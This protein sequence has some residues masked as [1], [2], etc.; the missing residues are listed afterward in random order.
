MTLGPEPAAASSVAVL[1]ADVDRR[2]RS[3][4]PAVQLRL[5]Y[6]PKLL[7]ESAVK[8]VWA[9]TAAI[10]ALAVRHHLASALSVAPKGCRGAASAL[11]IPTTPLPRRMPRCP[12]RVHSVRPG[13]RDEEVTP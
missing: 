10:L 7:G 8:S 5:K 6:R 9:L 4:T 12:P 13:D 3:D 2:L 11:S 1:A